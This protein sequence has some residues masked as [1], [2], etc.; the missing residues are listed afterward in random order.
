MAAFAWKVLAALALLLAALAMAVP[1][2]PALPFLLLAALAAE[3]GWPSLARRLAAHPSIGPMVRAWKERG[4]IPGSVR[5]FGL[6]GLAISA[7]TVWI[8]SAPV[9]WPI[10]ADLALL[11]A[12]AW[13]WTRPAA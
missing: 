10:G 5:V 2:L 8:G 7:A 9:W 13:L 12:A 3:R 6:V 11:A 1:V 4:A